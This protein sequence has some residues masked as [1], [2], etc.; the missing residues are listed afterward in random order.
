MFELLEYDANVGCKELYLDENLFHRALSD[1]EKRYHVKNPKG[2]DF[3]IFYLD[4]NDDIE[5]IDSY[6]AYI[7]RPY[8]VP[9][10]IYDETDRD[11]LYLKFFDGLQYFEFEELNEYT[12]VLT[13]VVLSY[14][15]MHVY[16][17]DPRILWFVDKNERLHVESELP[18]LPGDV[19]FYVQKEFKTGI[20]G[21]D[22]NRLSATYAFHNIFFLQWILD[23]RPLSKFKYATVNI[24]TAGGIGAVLT[25][26]K[27]F[28]KAFSYFGL[29]L[30]SKEERIGKFR[31]DMLDKYFSLGLI[32]E[33]ATDENTIEV[34]NQ[35]LL[36][37]TKCVFAT[38]GATDT[39]ILTGGFKK[40]LDE[41]FVA[42]FKDKKVLGILI[43]G[44]DF[45]SSGVSGDRK[46]A[47]VEQMLPTIHQWMDEDGYDRIFLATEDKDILKQMKDEF[48][49]QVIVVAQE[50]HSV[51][52][53]RKGQIISELEKEIFK[54]EDY[55]EQVE[56]TTINYFYALYML[57]RCDSFMCSGQCNGWDVVNDFNAGRFLRSYKFR[58][59]V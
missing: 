9:Y 48:G 45:L 4:N 40:D 49:K 55:D 44:T 20:D 14:T 7:P 41:Y 26:G 50:R 46:M 52:E 1:G 15:G 29:K 8:M 39:S 5:P 21:N 22:F 57:S 28:E 59:G 25:F 19:T 2:E 3:D 23:G 43:R 6:P 10:R 56:D 37:K 34:P 38:K 58:V 31:A 32:A 51:S 36:I 42:L 54:E 27:R 47:T 53:F 24:D 16:C 33:D 18:Q 17:N 11:T 35:V 13:K 30:I 12:I